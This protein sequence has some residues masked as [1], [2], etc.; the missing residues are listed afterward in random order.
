[1]FAMNWGIKLIAYSPLA[2]G[3]L[4][5]KYSENGSLPKGIRG[6][7]CKQLLPGIRS[8]LECLRNSGIQKQDCFAGSNQLVHL[9]RNY[10]DS[11]GEICG[12]GEG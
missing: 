11:W 10:S 8:L 4:T 3:L 7:A 5:G 6:L 2:L 12:T 9:Q 1:M